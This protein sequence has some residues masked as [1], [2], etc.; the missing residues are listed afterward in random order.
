MEKNK[1][2]IQVGGFSY[3]F[4]KLQVLIAS[5]YTLA[6]DTLKMFKCHYLISSRVSIP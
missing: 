4:I 1:D 6:S 3:L 2:W 5:Y